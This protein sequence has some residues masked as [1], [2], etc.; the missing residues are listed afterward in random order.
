MINVNLRGPFFLSKFFLKKL[1]KNE[2]CRIINISSIS[3]LLGGKLQ[4][5]YAI[6]KAGLISLSKSLNNLFGKK[7]FTINSIA[8]G[9]IKTKM[10]EK[11]INKKKQ[12]NIKIEKIKSPKEVSKIILKIISDRFKN[13]TG[14]VFK[15]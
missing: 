7:N 11:E 4:I 6:T 15:I 5:H 1:L 3:G 8:P 9:L 2:W 12:K 10:I 14:K 13:Q